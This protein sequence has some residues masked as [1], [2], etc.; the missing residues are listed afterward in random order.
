MKSSSKST[1][2]RSTATKKIAYSKFV[3]NVAV[4]YEI[5]CT[6]FFGYFF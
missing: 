1:K 5:F 4:A 2:Y 6:H 3:A